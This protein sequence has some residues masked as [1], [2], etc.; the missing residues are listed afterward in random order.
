MDHT[1]RKYLEHRV[2]KAESD[3]R[4]LV[5][6]ESRRANEPP[7][8]KAARRI[9]D[10][11]GRAKDKHSEARRSKVTRAA[12]IARERILFGSERE[13]LKAVKQLEKLKP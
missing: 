6:R 12:N 13:A 2:S 11:Y 3:K 9:V 10:A 7:A 8:V 4:D 5:Y 1:Q